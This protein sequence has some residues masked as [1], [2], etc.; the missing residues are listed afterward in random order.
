MPDPYCTALKA[1]NFSWKHYEKYVFPPFSHVVGAAILKLVKD[2]N[3]EIMLISKWTTQYWFPTMLP[4]L[5]DHHPQR[6]LGL[7]KLSLTFKPSEAHPLFPKLQLLAIILLGKPFKEKLKMSSLLSGK[8]K[9]LQNT[10]LSLTDGNYFVYK[11]VTI[12]IN[13]LFC[14]LKFLY[15]LYENGCYFSRL[16]SVC[17]VLSTVVYTEGY[18]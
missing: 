5:V 11:G 9:P 6:P 1:F 18:S 8:P 12:A 17:S 14:V 7:K 16:S 4:H 15:Y 2:N 3:I 13:H 10:N